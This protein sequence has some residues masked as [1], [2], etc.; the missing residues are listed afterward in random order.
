M[1]NVD[2]TNSESLVARL[3]WDAYL[4]E[5]YETTREGINEFAR[6]VG[7]LVSVA[8]LPRRM[9]MPVIQGDGAHENLRNILLSGT[10]S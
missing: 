7:S 6:F 2:N 3:S 10:Q 4:S 5:L 1:R 8:G 9:G